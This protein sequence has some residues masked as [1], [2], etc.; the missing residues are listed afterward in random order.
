MLF[1]VYYYVMKRNKLTPADEKAIAHLKNGSSQSPWDSS[2]ADW[3]RILRNYLRMT[4]VEL[5]QR[6]K[7]QQSHLAGIESG[8]TDPR[9]STVRR[10]YEALS[11]RLSLEPKPKQPIDDVLRDR[12]RAVALK[13]LNQSS[14]TMALENQAPDAET[15]QRMLEKQTDEIL[16]DRGNRLWEKPGD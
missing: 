13:R 8:K 4:Q 14:G 7:I 15:F 1:V 12:A 3:I 10:L 5:A 2:Y 16:A 9:I 11:C 6:A